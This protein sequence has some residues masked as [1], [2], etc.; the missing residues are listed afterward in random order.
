MTVPVMSETLLYVKVK[1]QSHMQELISYVNSF[2]TM[3][4]LKVCNKVRAT[5]MVTFKKINQKELRKQMTTYFI[6]A[7]S[8]NSNRYF[9]LKPKN[10]SRFLHCS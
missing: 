3:S 2:T 1:M 9:A 6:R 10:K 4:R 5:V 8:L 7:P